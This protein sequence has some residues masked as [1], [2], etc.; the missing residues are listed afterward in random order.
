MSEEAAKARAN[1]RRSVVSASPFA[2]DPTLQ[3]R[4]L[5]KIATP[6]GVWI[7]IFTWPPNSLQGFPSARQRQYL[8]MWNKFAQFL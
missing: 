8:Q 1:E 5:R 6:T 2:I 7:T 3:N 4:Q